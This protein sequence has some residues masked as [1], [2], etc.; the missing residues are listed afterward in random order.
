MVGPRIGSRRCCDTIK[1][2]T[3]AGS[4]NVK[5]PLPDTSGALEGRYGL[6]VSGEG[7]EIE[8]RERAEA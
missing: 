5:T 4:V 2:G 3:M 1:Y 6:D 7:Q 8:C